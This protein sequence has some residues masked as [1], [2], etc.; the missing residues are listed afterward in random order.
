M[1]TR[2]VVANYKVML[3]QLFKLIIIIIVIKNVM[4]TSVLLVK[5]IFLHKLIR[6]FILLFEKVIVH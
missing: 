1:K 5:I 3:Q 4:S 2:Q 6:K